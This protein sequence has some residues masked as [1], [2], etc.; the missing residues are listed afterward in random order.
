MQSVGSGDSPSCSQSCPWLGL[1]CLFCST[2]STTLGTGTPQQTLLGELELRSP[3][4]S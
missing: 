4:G 2:Q 3:S 1:A